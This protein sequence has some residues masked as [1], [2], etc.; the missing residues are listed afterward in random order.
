MDTYQAK[1]P[2]EKQLTADGAG[3]GVGKPPA[4]W[5]LDAVEVEVDLDLLCRVESCV[6]GEG[7]AVDAGG[8][9]GEDPPW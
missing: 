7:D 6:A 2:R 5:H 1:G 3:G 4:L 9:A 8:E